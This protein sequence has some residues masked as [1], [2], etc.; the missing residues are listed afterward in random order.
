MDFAAPQ[1]DKFF[2]YRIKFLE[3][4][5]NVESKRFNRVEKHATVKVLAIKP[6]GAAI[7]RLHNKPGEYVE[8]GKDY[9]LNTSRHTVL[10]REFASYESLNGRT[11]DVMNRGK[12]T[13]KSSGKDYQDY[14][15]LVA[16]GE[17][18][19]KQLLAFQGAE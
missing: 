12:A 10:A 15:I 14:V 7:P 9:M 4:L 2:A 5:R 1:G 11:F 18:S 6:D 17:M 16:E 19:A 3:D 8:I 13:S